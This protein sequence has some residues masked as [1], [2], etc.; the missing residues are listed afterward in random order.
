MK[1][2]ILAVYNLI[3]E[4]EVK[5]AKNIMTMYKVMAI[6]ETVLDEIT[7][8]KEVIKNENLEG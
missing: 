5:G 3:N 7:E 8:G 6:L 4:I 1:D 2:K